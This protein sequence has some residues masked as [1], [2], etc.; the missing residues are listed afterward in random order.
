M[1][2]YKPR[3]SNGKFSPLPNAPRDS[4]AVIFIVAAILN[5]IAFYIIYTH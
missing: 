3:H 4:S 2:E 1:E 5:T